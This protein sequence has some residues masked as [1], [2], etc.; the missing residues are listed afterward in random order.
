MKRKSALIKFITAVFCLLF[1][2]SFTSCSTSQN[3]LDR[4]KKSSYSKVRAHQPSWNSSTSPRTRYKLKRTNKKKSSFKK[5]RGR[6]AKTK[7][8][9]YSIFK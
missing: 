7:S 3:S 1:V 4:G 6:S 2:F 9:T 5:N 8:R